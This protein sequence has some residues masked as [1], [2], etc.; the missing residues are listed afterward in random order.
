MTK[1]DERIF[2]LTKILRLETDVTPLI[3]QMSDYSWDFVGQTALLDKTI[4]RSVLS[5]YAA[6]DL[7][8]D[9]I[10]QWAD[11][12]ELLEDVDYPADE[13]DTISAI[14]HELANPDLEGTLSPE[15]AE[16][17]LAKL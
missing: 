14:L 8:A 3:K 12:L 10:Y 16:I 5:R 1:D 4:L 13:A 6:G 17:L 9:A 7:T 2:I 11:F 15:R